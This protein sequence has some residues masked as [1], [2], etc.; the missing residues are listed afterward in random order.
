MVGGRMKEKHIHYIDLIR[1]LAIFCVLYNHSSEKG[2]YLYA[3]PASPWLKTFYYALSSYIAIG[4]PLFFM[5]SGAMLLGKEESYKD[6]IKKRASKMLIVLL[7]FSAISYCF[8]T[9]WDGGSL[10]IQEFVVKLFT[11]DVVV[12][13]WFLYVYLLFLLALPFLRMLARQMKDWHYGLLLL[14]YLVLDGVIKIIYFY[15]GQ[16]VSF[17][18]DYPWCHRIIFWPLM[19]YYLVHKMPDKFYEKKFRW[20]GFL[21]SIIA[22]GIIVYM[23]Y[24]RALPIEEFTDYD[25]GLFTCSLTAVFGIYTFYIIQYVGR[26]WNGTS[27]FGKTLRHFGT[28]TFGVYLLERII[29]S[30]TLPVWEI[31]DAYMPRMCATIIWNVVVFCIGVIF[32]SILKK[33]PYIRKLL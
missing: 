23:S 28:C 32:V 15:L 9:I 21:A 19:G 13:Y 24:E 3:Y 29:T 31:F 33:I 18:Y 5:I 7:V 8:I 1:V 17:V 20:L 2:Y 16:E 26:N 10:Q 22:I 6:I 30:I 11:N 14:F 12:S 25:K 27:F 4:V